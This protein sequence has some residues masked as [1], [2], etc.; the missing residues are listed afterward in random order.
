VTLQQAIDGE[1]ALQEEIRSEARVAKLVDIAKRLEGLY[2][3]ASTNAHGGVSGDRPLDE[4]V[5]LDREPRPDMPVTQVSMK[6]VEPAGLVKFDFLGLKTL[7]VIAKA[8]DHM[9]DRGIELDINT[10]P[11]DDPATFAMLCK[12]DTTGVFQ[13]ESSG[14]RDILSNM[15]P[16]SFEDIIAIGALYRPGPMDNIPS[17]IRRKH[18]DEEPDNY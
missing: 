2:R 9:K 10:L 15:K 13:L 1:P 12:G 3:H 14:M 17:Y 5:P 4:L 6:H 7:T 8:L 16:D 11:F 18:G